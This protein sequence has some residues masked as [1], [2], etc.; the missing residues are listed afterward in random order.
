MKWKKSLALALAGLMTMSLIAGCGSS[1][2]ESTAKAPPTKYIRFV[3]G[4]EP[5][6][7]DP[8]K[9]TGMPEAKIEA[10][11]FEGLMT[12]DKD[13]AI[14]AGTA[15]KWTISQDGKVYTFTLRANAKWSN[16]EPVTAKD[17]EYTWKKTLDPKFAS[18]YAQQLYFIQGAEEYNTGKGDVA[19]VGIKAVDDRTLQVTLAQPTPF[20]LSVLAHHAYYPVNK[21]LDEATPNWMA[22]P[23][24][25][26]GNGPFQM[27]SWTHNSKIETVKNTHYWDAANVKMPQLDFLLTDNTGT[28]L[29]MFDSGQADYVDQLPPADLQRLLKEG[30]VKTAPYLTNIYYAFNTKKAPF[31]NVK[32][33]K[34][35][36]LAIDREALVK[37]LNNGSIAAYG[38]IPPGVPDADKGSDFRK[39]GGNLTKNADIAEAKKLL[40]EAGY[41]DGKGLPPV[42][43]IYNTNEIHKTVAEA[44]QEMW[45]KNLGVA[46]EL[47][48]QEWKVFL[49]NRKVGN[50]MVA[51]HGWVGDYEDPLT[52]MSL[53]ESSNGNNDCKYTN[54]KYDEMVK[55]SYLEADPKKRMKLFHDMEKMVV[56]EDT[57]VAP[58]YFPPQYILAKPY[59]KGF[60]NTAIGL[61]YFKH[62]YVE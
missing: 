30:K 12:H 58:L 3:V 10:N 40:A 14:A 61:P 18:K 5:E 59:A 35:F 4:V 9:S 43:L 49:Q 31:D 20:F 51:R 32:V 45:K 39:L 42:A 26:V 56:E 28:A 60:V 24:T 8:R 34:A 54:P 22:D 27:K 50:F 16:G 6:T 33:R 11:L 62:A 52:F 25:F 15:E 17:F 48:N 55:Q 19:A 13:G 2:K 36:S 53:L 23:K 44:I 1:N 29:S 38:F 47:Q 7:L 46:V 37:N 21:K 41:P 57:V